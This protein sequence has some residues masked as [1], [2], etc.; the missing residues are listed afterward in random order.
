L[1]TVFPYKSTTY[2]IVKDFVGLLFFVLTN[3]SLARLTCEQNHKFFFK[4]MKVNT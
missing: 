1:K 3:L 4:N 2:V